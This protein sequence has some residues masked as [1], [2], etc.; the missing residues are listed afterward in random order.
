VIVNRR[1]RRRARE[2]ESSATG[3][4]TAKFLLQQLLH[5]HAPNHLADDQQLASLIRRLI[6]IHKR[7]K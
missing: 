7:E 1:V 2:A 3:S 6:E 4:E 5:R